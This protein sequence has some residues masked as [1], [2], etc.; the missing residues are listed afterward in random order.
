MS[1]RITDVR[2]ITKPISSPIRNAYIDFTK[3]TTSL[4]AVVTD[5]C[6]SQRL[7]GR[8]LTTAEAKAEV[9]RRL[10]E[11]RNVEVRTVDAGAPG[12]MVDGTMLFG[13]LA[14]PAVALAGPEQAGTLLRAAFTAVLALVALIIDIARVRLVV[15]D[16]HSALAAFSASI[17]FVRRRLWRCAALYALNLLALAALVVS[18]P[19]VATMM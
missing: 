1:V 19:A 7:D 2:E 17:R 13:P 18:C 9:E 3:M 16:R 15:E 8:D 4:V 12:G 10:A 11:F 5:G 6:A 14:G